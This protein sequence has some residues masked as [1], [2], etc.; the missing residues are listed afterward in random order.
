MLCDI[1]AHAMLTGGQSTLLARVRVRSGALCRRSSSKTQ[2]STNYKVL[3]TASRR[4]SDISS[5]Y[6][7]F[8]NRCKLLPLPHKSLINALIKYDG[9]LS[10]CS[11]LRLFPNPIGAEWMLMHNFCVSLAVLVLARDAY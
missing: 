10:Y 5:C 2:V 3:C 11:Q 4:P 1:A 6:F 8:A 9:C 7:L